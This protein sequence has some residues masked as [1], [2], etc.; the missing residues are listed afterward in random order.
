MGLI[1][2][3]IGLVV[4]IAVGI[5]WGRNTIEK[6]TMRKAHDEEELDKLHQLRG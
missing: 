2:F 4:V 3:I 6:D 5:L 1:I